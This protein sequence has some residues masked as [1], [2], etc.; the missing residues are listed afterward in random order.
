MD[1]I[2]VAREQREKHKKSARKLVSG[3]LGS[4]LEKLQH[5]ISSECLF[6]A[7]VHRE[8]IQ[9]NKKS[10]VISTDKLGG[11]VCGGYPDQAVRFRQSQ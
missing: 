8:R 3:G 9:L 4:L 5:S 2:G 7:V 1:L 11:R 10:G 6:Y